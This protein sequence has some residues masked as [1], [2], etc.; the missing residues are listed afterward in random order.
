M[1]LVFDW[2]QWIQALETEHFD[3]D[4]VFDIKTI[5]AHFFM[6]SIIVISDIVLGILIIIV[7]LIEGILQTW[8]AYW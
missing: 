8:L 4:V 1:S 7:H 2:Y 3:R 5:I 6:A